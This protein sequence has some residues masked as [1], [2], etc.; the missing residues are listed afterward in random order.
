MWIIKILHYTEETVE[1]K[2]LHPWSRFMMRNSAPPVALFKEKEN[3][4]M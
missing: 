4:A 3:G 1:P 2:Q